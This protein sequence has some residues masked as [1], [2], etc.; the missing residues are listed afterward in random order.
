MKTSIVLAALLAT[1]IP[2]AGAA[3]PPSPYAGQQARDVK[4]LSPAEVKG[5]LTGEGLGMAKAGELNH[6]PGP[7]HVL[8]LAQPLGLTPA[9]N[10]RILNIAATMKASAVLLGGEIVDSERALDRAFAQRTIDEDGLRAATARIAELQGRLRAVH[11]SAHLATRAV[12][13][14]DQIAIYDHMRGYAPGAPAMHHH[15]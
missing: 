14:P 2:A 9:Q 11:L 7:R 5:Y 12:L 13:T 10:R 3:Q 4:T 15:V 1:L 6:Y 8:A